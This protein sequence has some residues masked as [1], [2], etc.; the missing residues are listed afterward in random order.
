MADDVFQRLLHI[1]HAMLQKRDIHT[2]SFPNVEK[3]AEA[4]RLK[5][6]S[7]ADLPNHYDMENHLS[8]VLY[9]FEHY[10]AG[11]VGPGKPSLQS[12]ADFKVLCNT[13]NNSLSQYRGYIKAATEMLEEE[14]QELIETRR[15]TINEVLAGEPDSRGFCLVQYLR[16][17]SAVHLLTGPITQERALEN[18]LC[19]LAHLAKEG[20]M[21]RMG[22]KSLLT[23]KFLITARQ[24]NLSSYADFEQFIRGELV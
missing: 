2:N 21:S 16:K 8:L 20:Q 23:F 14:K 17:L 7:K 5:K 24:F 15:Q 12:Y 4:S 11:D 6:T 19:F 18:I 22:L 3:R 9:I 1:A 10:V 13:F